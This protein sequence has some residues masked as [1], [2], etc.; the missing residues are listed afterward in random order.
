M[1]KEYETITEI[2]G[3]LVFAEIDEPVG[4]DEIVEIE[5]PDGGLRR[6]QVLETTSEHV[7]IQV[8]EGTSGIDRNSSVRF[9]GETLQMPLTE[10]LLGRVLSGSGEPIDGGPQIEPDEEREIVGAAINP[11]AREYPEEFIQTGVAAIDGMNTLIRGQKL[12]IFSG[13]GLPDRKS[14]V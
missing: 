9:L 6:G 3:P 8:F 7:A 10:E 12:P 2:S 13:S 14:V 1:Q 5:T 11:T 4:Y